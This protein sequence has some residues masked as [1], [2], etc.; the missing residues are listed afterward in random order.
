MSTLCRASERTAARRR[1]ERTMRVLAAA[2]A[3][4]LALL[5][6]LP[7]FDLLRRAGAGLGWATLTTPD[8]VSAVAAGMGGALQATGLAMLP[9]AFVAVP[10]GLAVAVYL[11]EIARPGW[12]TALVDRSIRHLALLPPVVFGLLGFGGLVVVI[13]LP[14]GTPLLAGAVLGLSILP[15]VVLAGQFVLREVPVQIRTAG[16][17]MGASPLQVVAAHVLPRAAPAMLGA[18]FTALARAVGEA[19]PLL[20]VGF[21][22]FAAGRPGALAEPGIPLPALVIRWA[23]SPEPL[24]TAKAAAAA[25]VLLLAVAALGVTGSLLERR[26]ARA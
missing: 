19:A 23:Q 24:F 26:G 4:L 13:G 15:R 1:R 6:A 5:L 10:L 12:G 8:S 16:H 17:A 20:L 7:L 22:G 14:V 21:L 25:L 18:S 3:W 11:E 9:V 2:G